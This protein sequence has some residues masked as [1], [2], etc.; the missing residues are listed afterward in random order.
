L[1]YYRISLASIP[2]R[3]CQ[4]LTP[5][6][7]LLQTSLHSVSNTSYQRVQKNI[8]L[9]LTEIDLPRDRTPTG[10]E[11]AAAKQDALLELDQQVRGGR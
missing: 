6:E 1:I 2:S 9:P 8:I 4:K 11:A 7:H 10:E 3:N 5:P